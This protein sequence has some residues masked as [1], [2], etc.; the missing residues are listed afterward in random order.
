MQL[1]K[2]LL[3]ARG[4]GKKKVFAFLYIL[5]RVLRERIV[6]DR[7]N[8]VIF[9]RRFNETARA[10]ITRA[11]NSRLSRL[12][13]TITRHYVRG[14]SADVAGRH[15]V[16]AALFDGAH[17]IKCIHQTKEQRIG[18]Y[19]TPHTEKIDGAKNDYKIL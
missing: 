19:L 2:F 13:A 17:H 12:R 8:L 7:G 4:Y 15:D 5:L 10:T 3:L 14:A 16:R 6:E 1:F 11:F 9:T 18:G